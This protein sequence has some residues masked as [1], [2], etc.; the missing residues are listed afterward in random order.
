M[1]SQQVNPK[2]KKDTLRDMFDDSHA[3]ANADAEEG[4]ELDD[5]VKNVEMLVYVKENLPKVAMTGLIVENAEEAEMEADAKAN[6]ADE[7]D[8]FFES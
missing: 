2:N 4:E 7:S 8:Y 1:A 3:D 6:P 5:S